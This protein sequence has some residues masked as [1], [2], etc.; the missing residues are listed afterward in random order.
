M[1]SI[2][3][4]TNTDLF[5]DPARHPISKPE[6]GRDGVEKKDA[7]KNSAQSTGVKPETVD[8]GKLTEK[9]NKYV[10]STGTR[11]SFKYDERLSRPVIIVRDQETGEII[12][13]IP[14]EEMLNLVEKM[15]DKNGFLF[16]GRG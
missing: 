2:K 13:Q 6:E 12:R 10:R 14:Q 16:R 5:S 3:H 11:L 8:F 9:I 1:E 4:I 15:N 7:A